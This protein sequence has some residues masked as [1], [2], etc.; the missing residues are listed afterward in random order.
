MRF[1]IVQ[2]ITCVVILTLLVYGCVYR[3]TTALSM[4][5]LLT[6]AWGFGKWINDQR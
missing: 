5:S 6:A 1:S 4:A 2:L 3:D